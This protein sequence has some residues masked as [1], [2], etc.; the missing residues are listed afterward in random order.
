[1]DYTNKEKQKAIEV[2]ADHSEKV[3]DVGSTTKE[4]IVRL[5][6]KSQFI[7]APTRWWIEAWGMK[8]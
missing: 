8:I 2:E 3:S 7:I 6:V 1:M 4:L 5:T